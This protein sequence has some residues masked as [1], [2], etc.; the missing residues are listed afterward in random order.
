MIEYTPCWK[1]K[2]GVSLSEALEYV[3]SHP[4][5]SYEKVEE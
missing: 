5:D 1:V 2:E 3:D 4:P